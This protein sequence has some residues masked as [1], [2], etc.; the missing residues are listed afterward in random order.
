[1]KRGNLY[2]IF[3]RAID[4][5]G[6][7]AGLILL[8]PLMAVAGLAVRLFDGP[9]VLYRQLRPGL[10]GRPFTLYKFR[11]MTEERGRSG[12]KSDPG[13]S[14][15]T[16]SLSDAQRLTPLGR[17]LREHSL[18]ELPEL[19]NVLKGEMS[20]VGPRPLL[21][22]YLSHYSLEQARRHEV[23]PGMTGW[24][25]VNGRNALDWE[26]K[27]AHD[28]YYVENR[29]LLLDLRIMLMTLGAVL[30]RRGVSHAGEATM[31]KFEGSGDNN[32]PG[33]TS[34]EGAGISVVAERSARP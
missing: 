12:H 24:A 3:K 6:S 31:P 16:N 27:F 34:R 23:K 25:Q 5:A 9:P 7:L 21:M 32:A 1:M 30:S 4:I 11:T 8:S 29:S 14:S 15:G 18:D 33:D 10:G 13:R 20:L 26:E 28:I 17:F 22:E 2:P 19:V